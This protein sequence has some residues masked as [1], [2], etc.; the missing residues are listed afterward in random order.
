MIG[1]EVFGQALFCFGELFG[2]G[3]CAGFYAL[4]EF[5]GFLALFFFFGQDWGGC[6]G[7][8]EFGFGLGLGWPG[9]FGD[10]GYGFRSG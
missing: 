8:V 10:F 1:F 2:K 7:E 3:F 4:V 9:V 5:G 6:G